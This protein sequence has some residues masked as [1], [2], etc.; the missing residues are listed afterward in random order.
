MS[1]EQSNEQ[2]N[3]YMGCQPVVSWIKQVQG[4]K[5][6][7]KW[8]ESQIWNSCQGRTLWA[9]IIFYRRE[10]G[11]WLEVKDEIKQGARIR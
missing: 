11:E 3:K 9:L 2:M 5:E 4:K 6:C 10:G 8:Q 1:R 7:G